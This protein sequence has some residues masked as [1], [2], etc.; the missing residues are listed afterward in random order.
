MHPGT[1]T[2]VSSGG[3]DVEGE[4]PTQITMSSGNTQIR[5]IE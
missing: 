5:I 4:H 2:I 1:S 3:D